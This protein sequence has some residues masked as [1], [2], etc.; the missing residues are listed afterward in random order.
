MNKEKK[1][2]YRA[3]H[4]EE[5]KAYN[6]AYNATH[7]E[8]KKAYMATYSATHREEKKANDAAYSAA[9]KEEKKKRNAAYY[10]THREER[11]AKDA[12]YRAA[13]KEEIKA[14]NAAYNAAHYAATKEQRKAY[15]TAR[16]E[17]ISAANHHSY[18]FGSKNKPPRE[19]YKGMPFYSGWDPNK[20][21]SFQA[22]ADWIISR[23]GKRPEGCSLHIVDHA[24]GFVPG[25]LEWTHPK[26]QVAE[27]M[28]KIIAN[29]KNKIRTALELAEEALAEL[30]E[31]A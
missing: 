11:K 13:H 26:K 5:Q 17:C 25:N 14:Y 28:F 21:G 2:A 4:K 3:A 8:E 20:G 9:H 12:A 15:R 10:A 24:K 31:A 30:A 22:A 6:A 19:N 7:R 1:K 23:L 16:T 29:Q 27:Q 18:V